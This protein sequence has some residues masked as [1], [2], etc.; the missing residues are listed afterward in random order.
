MGNSLPVV[1]LGTGRTAVEI[2]AAGWHTCALLDNATVKCWGDNFFEQLGLGDTLDRGDGPGEMGNSLPVVSLGTGRTVERLSRGGV[3]TC[4]LL[5]DASLKCWGTNFN[6]SLGLGDTLGRGH[7]PGEMGDALPAVALGTGRT[8]TQTSAGA[9]HTCALLDDGTVRCWGRNDLGQLGLGDTAD[10][11]DEPG[12]MGDALPVVTLFDVT[13]PTV[14]LRTPPDGAAYLRGEAVAADFSCADEI[15]GSGIA[16]CVG[17]VPDGDPVDTSSLGDHA[18]SGTATDG[19]GNTA[20][21]THTYTVADPRPDGWVKLGAAGAYKGD[22]RYNTSA[23]GQTARGSAAPGRTVTYFVVMQNDAPSPE[24]LLVRG[25][26]SNGRFRV[27]Y[28]AGGE[29]VTAAVTGGSYATSVLGAGAV[30]VVKVTVKVK[31]GA[32][33]GSTLAGTVTVR[34]GTDDTFKDRVGLTTRRV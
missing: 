32:P 5:D 16:T 3:H 10:R 18:F 25:T 27:T 12:E 17:T 34:S 14:D 11:G 4:A 9:Y 33:V 20:T 6:G 8:A 21:V 1:A 22:D 23:V 13:D 15:G 19:A 28:S 2:A 7:D 29:D 31:A 24:A 30:Q 26:A